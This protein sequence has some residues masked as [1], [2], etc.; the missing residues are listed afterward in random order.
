MDLLAKQID[1]YLHALGAEKY[2]LQLV[3]AQGLMRAYRGVKEAK[4]FD[5]NMLAWLKAKNAEGYQIYCRPIGWQYVL[6]DD[7]TPD[8]LARAKEL[9]PCVV[10]ETSPA[11]FQA[12][13]RLNAVPGSREEALSIC[14]ELADLLGADRG[15]AEPD[16]VGR[17]PAFTNR[18][19]KYRTAKGYPF[20]K[21]PVATPVKTSF[22]PQGGALCLKEHSTP[23]LN[24]MN[25]PV[26]HAG[27]DRSRSDFN[28][29]CMLIRQG[30][31]DGHIREQLERLSEK[32]Q[33]RKDDYIGRTIANARKAVTRC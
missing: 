18:K 17:L 22:Y 27:H 24:G 3:H 15:S 12:W 7:L 33:G 19:E 25:A 14:R 9:A 20:V 4:D 28:L 30:K 8:N 21:L 10:M 2:T 13:L 29:A 31:T 32:A 1:R 5:G 11:N 16:H 26:H 23:L 6:L